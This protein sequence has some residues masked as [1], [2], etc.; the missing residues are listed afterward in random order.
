MYKVNKLWL[1]ETHLVLV[2]GGHVLLCGAE[3][4]AHA[5]QHQ[6]H[7]VLLQAQQGA[8]VLIH[9]AR[10]LV[11][12]TKA[13]KRYTPT[14]VKTCSK[15][16]LTKVWPIYRNNVSLGVSVNPQFQLEFEEIFLFFL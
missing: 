11:E 12:W 7:G 10:V 9:Q 13:K 2:N 6:V 14:L 4:E 5:E 16:F 8:D 1:I 3:V 15:H